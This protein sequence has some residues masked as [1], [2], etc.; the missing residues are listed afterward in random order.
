MDDAADLS[1]SAYF[2][3]SRSRR[4][5]GLFLG[6]ATFVML[7][8]LI[9]RRALVR[10]YTASIP[11]FYQPSTR[12]GRQ[13]NGAFEALEALNL[14]TINVLSVGLTMTGGLL[15]AFDIST[16]D[17]MKRK[18]RAK[19]GTDGLEGREE[20]ADAEMESWVAEILARRE[21]KEKSAGA[22]RNKPNS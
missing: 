6:G 15:W 13:V 21:E 10:R 16:L 20:D 11:P 4:Q 1:L 18:V 14:A 17:D 9:T 22:T 5:L 12:P 19:I 8:A 7:S 3:S 2:T